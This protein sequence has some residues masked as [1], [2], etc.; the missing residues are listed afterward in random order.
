MSILN[1]AII[2]QDLVWEN[3]EAN[4]K[5]FEQEIKKIQ[6]ADLIILPEMFNSGF[7]MQPNKVAQT[8]SGNTIKW[9]KNIANKYKTAI[10]GSLAIAEDNK[11]FNRLLTVLPNGD[12]HQYNKKHLFRMGGEHN[13]YTS[14]TKK[15]II[16]YMNWRIC[17]LICYDLRF[18]VW[19][20]N[21]N[22]YD[23]L[24][25]VANWPNTRNYAWETLL[26]ARAIENQCYT[27]GVNRIGTDGN[28]IKYKGNSLI[29]NPKGEI[30]TQMDKHTHIST[31]KLN[32]NEL[33]NF[34]QKFPAYLD[35]DNFTINAN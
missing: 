31:T 17:T 10:I 16:N 26:K 4:H 24:I 8:T 23:L 1:I 15:T 2:Q 13:V 18:P 7:T 27:I 33:N 35:A 19:S 11:Y 22:N 12:I 21:K 32:I 30:I 3:A 25:Y 6:N 14:G 28:N 29:I 5:L 20:R 9:L 34:K